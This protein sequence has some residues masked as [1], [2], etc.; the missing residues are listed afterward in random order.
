[1]TASRERARQ[2]SLRPDHWLVRGRRPTRKGLI[3]L[4]LALV[5]VAV[6]GQQVVSIM[7]R[8]LLADDFNQPNGLLTNEF[9]FYNPHDRTAV[10]SP[11][12]IATSGSLYAHDNAGWTGVPDRMPPG[13]RSVAGTDSSVFRVVTRRND[14]QDAAVSLSLLVQRFVAP[15]SG[16]APT[17]QGVHIFLRY[18]NPDLLYAVSVDRHDGV[19]AIKKKVPGGPSAGGTY[20]T[21]ATASAKTGLGHWE[22]VKASAV[23]NGEGG[24]EI[25]LWLNGRLRL[26]A[27]D[28]GTGDTEPITRPGR[29]G[30]RGDYTEFMFRDF[31]VTKA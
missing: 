6:A 15:G 27:V 11:I 30:L 20:Y 7:D 2:S 12:W 16:P 10:T 14:F 28:S 29:V 1:L 26:S 18:Q 5:I 13:P 21:L 24:V 8:P 9:A 23:N 25:Q 19:I 3:V 22:Q 17:W 4:I 31:T